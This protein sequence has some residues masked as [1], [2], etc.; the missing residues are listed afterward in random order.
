MHTKVY[1]TQLY[2]LMSHQ[3]QHHEVNASKL[4]KN[5]HSMT[6]QWS[7]SPGSL[8]SPA[9]KSVNPFQRCDNFQSIYYFIE[10]NTVLMIF[11]IQYK[12]TCALM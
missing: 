7:E 5:L 10:H 3:Y 2:F 4:K 8:K 12:H 11:L 6:G 1:I 9:P